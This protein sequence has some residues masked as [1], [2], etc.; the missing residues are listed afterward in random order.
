MVHRLAS[1]TSCTLEGSTAWPYSL[2]KLIISL[3]DLFAATTEPENL[4]E[5]IG[6]YNTLHT[7]IYSNKVNS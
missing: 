6:L 5:V 1:E 3:T 7:D 4:K 2:K